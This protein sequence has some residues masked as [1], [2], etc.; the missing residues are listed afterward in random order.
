MRYKNT[1][2]RNTGSQSE[3]PALIS[4]GCKSVDVSGYHEYTIKNKTI[5]ISSPKIRKKIILVTPYLSF[6]FKGRSFVDIGCNT[7]V[8]GLKLLADG[9][10]S[11]AILLDHDEDCINVLKDLKAETL[12]HLEFTPVCSSLGNTSVSCDIGAAFALIHWIYALTE[13]CDTLEKCVQLLKKSSTQGLF[14]EWI[15]P[16]DGAFIKN[17]A[18]RKVLTERGLTYSKK[19]F[20]T[21]LKNVYGNA[22]YIGKVSDTREIWLASE[23]EVKL[24]ILVS[25]VNN[26]KLIKL[27]AYHIV[28]RTKR[29]FSQ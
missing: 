11:N 29:K 8:I 5:N 13:N 2:G 19:E 14:I 12:A 4:D 15:D 23:H 9:A 3:Q 21:A 28:T 7:G 26:I 17:E 25:L 27:S 1:F 6:L 24:P 18:M 22:K 20:I 10:V 16:S